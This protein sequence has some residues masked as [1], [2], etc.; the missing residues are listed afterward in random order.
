MAFIKKSDRILPTESLQWLGGKMR[1]VALIVLAAVSLGATACKTTNP[2]QMSAAPAYTGAIAHVMDP[3]TIGSSPLNRRAYISGEQAN[4]SVING[5]QS[6]N[7]L[8]MSGSLES[9]QFGDRIQV[10]YTIDKMGDRYP[11]VAILPLVIQFEQGPQKSNR[12]S[13][14]GAMLGETT[15]EQRMKL[16]QFGAIISRSIA[17]SS[18]DRPVRQGDVLV[19]FSTGDFLEGLSEVF[20]SGE[21]KVTGAG[22]QGRI[23]GQTLYLGRKAVVVYFAGNESIES[24]QARFTMTLSGYA[25]VDVMT[26]LYLT[27]HIV[28]QA[29]GHGPLGPTTIREEKK[30]AI[31]F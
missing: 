24:N 13:I 8:Y 23:S 11:P 27:Q 17:A 28:F 14:G 16:E 5:Q 3:I 19:S 1:L 20:K 12:M 26:G 4:T 15:P 25:L 31:S 2:D 22:F 6:F 21:A 9:Y 30:S 29:A 18:N 7:R 10:T